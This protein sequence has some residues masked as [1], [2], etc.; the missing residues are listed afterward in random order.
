MQ[1]G[2]GKWTK[3]LTHRTPARDNATGPGPPSPSLTAT[4]VSESV[5]PLLCEFL[6]WVSTRPRTYA[7]AMDAWRST[8]PGHT[9]W[10]D[11]LLAGLVEVGDAAT[12]AGL[13]VTLTERGR[14]VLATAHS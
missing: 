12:S 10:E 3:S 4:D 2:C 7:E 14:D 6:T 9:V 13:M 8:C 1:V 11:A 5:S